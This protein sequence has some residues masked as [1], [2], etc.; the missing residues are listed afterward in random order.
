MK[1][2]LLQSCRGAYHPTRKAPFQ[3][4]QGEGVPHNHLKHSKKELQPLENGYYC[5]GLQL[6]Y[7][8]KGNGRITQKDLQLFRASPYAPEW[9]GNI[10]ESKLSDIHRPTQS[11]LPIGRLK[12]YKYK[13]SVYGGKK[14][15]ARAGK[16]GLAHRCYALHDNQDYTG[17]SKLHPSL[18]QGEGAPRNHVKYSKKEL[19][20]LGE[21]WEW[22]F[23]RTFY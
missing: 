5:E 7:R 20:P 9:S 13:K 11:R 17:G 15:P 14:S 4:S 19:P 1:S 10:H 21:G 8:T 23:R 12:N 2:Q 3:P 16:K 6:P 22:A 18:P